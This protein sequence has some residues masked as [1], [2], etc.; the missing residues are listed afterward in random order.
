MQVSHVFVL[1]FNTSPNAIFVVKVLIKKHIIREKKTE[2][3][4]REKKVL[5]ILS[6]CNN[7][8]VRLYCTFQD[9]ERLYFVLTYAKNGELLPHIN[10]K[11]PFSLNCCQYYAA[12]LLLALEVL[13]SKGIVHR[14]L[15]P[16][17]ILFDENWHILITDFGSA[18][19]VSNEDTSKKD[20]EGSPRRKNSFVGTAQYVSP[21]ILTD[22]EAT[23]A[24]D[25][26][27]YGCILFQMISGSAPFQAGSDYLIF[28]KILKLEYEFPEGF[29]KAAKDLIEKLL[30]LNSCER[31]GATDSK[32]YSSI[33]EHA[34]FKGIDWN[35]LGHPP[36]IGLENK[37]EECRIPDNLEPG[38]DEQ[39]ASLLQLG[40]ESDLTSTPRR[41][42]TD[43]GRK[44]TDLTPSEIE[45]RLDVQKKDKWHSL[46]QGNLILKQGLVDKRKGLFARRRMFLLTL[47]PHLYYVDPT[48]MVL[49][50]E[51]PFSADMRVEAKNFKTFFV[52]TVSKFNSLTFA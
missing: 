51:I 40:L 16:E 6:S 36:K 17:N 24:S 7:L 23:Y 39:R 27:A 38:L 29:D 41:K 43:P 4:T 8:F 30:V 52:H 1:C 31:L 12:E 19:I 15:K 42:K 5:Q 21:E 32:P 35:N 3:V 13:N 46:V 18:K 48:N 10:K 26:W 44:I 20:E 28:Q 34:F 37:E 50:G 49:K 47:G 22:T 11:V 2:Y 14:D 25:L 45:Q 33:R 9:A